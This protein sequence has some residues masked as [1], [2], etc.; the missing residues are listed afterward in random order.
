MGPRGQEAFTTEFAEFT[1]FTEKA[2]RACAHGWASWGA[3]GCAPTYIDVLEFP[4]DDGIK[5]V[6]VVFLMVEC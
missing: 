1:E 6:W 2:D 5:S 3:A 4:A